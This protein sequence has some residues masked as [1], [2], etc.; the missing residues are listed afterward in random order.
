[1]LSTTQPSTLDLQPATNWWQPTAGLTWQWQIV[2]MDIDTS[3]E[4][5]VYDIDL[6]VDQAIVDELH[7]KGRKVICYMSVG[8][9]ED[10]RPDKDNFPAEESH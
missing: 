5:D 8:S 10:W 6:Y 1:M 7:A 4:A 9:R 2:N 3:I